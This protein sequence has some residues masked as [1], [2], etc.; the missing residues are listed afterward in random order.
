MLFNQRSA[1]SYFIPMS[2]RIS[3]GLATGMGGGFKSFPQDSI[4]RE[5]VWGFIF[6][7]LTLLEFLVQLPR[8][9]SLA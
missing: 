7:L 4:S 5:K 9:E 3:Y 2:S 6:S 8:G 1:F